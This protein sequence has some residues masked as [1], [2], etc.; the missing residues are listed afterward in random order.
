MRTGFVM[1]CHVVIYCDGCGDL[2]SEN[3][4]EGI[5][6]NSVHQA[7]GYLNARSAG[8]GWLYDGDK[9]LCDG[10][11][12]VTR[13]TEQGHS[14]PTFPKSLRSHTCTVCGIHESEVLS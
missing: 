12:A 8:V 13:C 4:S 9:V 7:V 1:E 5:C 11:I 10:C 14:F 3:G 6:F 2:Y